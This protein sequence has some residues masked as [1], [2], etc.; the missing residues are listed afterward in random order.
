MW[1]Q[2]KSIARHIQLAAARHT[3]PHAATRSLATTPTRCLP[4]RPPSA[5]NGRLETRAQSSAV[6]SGT[7][8]TPAVQAPID[9][10]TSG[11][12]M[13][14][15]GAIPEDT[16]EDDNEAEQ[17]LT[18]A[19]SSESLQ[20]ILW[21]PTHDPPLSASSLPPDYILLDALSSLLV[22]LQ[23]QTQNRA[24]YPT[25]SGPPA[26]PTLAL[27][28]PIEG[29]DYVVDNTMQEIARQAGADVVVLDA[30]H[31]AANEWGRF[32]KGQ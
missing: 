29:S 31:I 3:P 19:L 2:A 32:G 26:E 20:G 17:T 22:T 8:P 11:A 13:E 24:A 7:S 1:R 12:L 14:S 4:R 21:S 18:P 23:P 10:P 16:P 27:Y 28:C 15:S 6:P 5:E 25:S 30:A 9:E